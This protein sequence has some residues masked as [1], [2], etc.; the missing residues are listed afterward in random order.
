MKS[1]DDVRAKVVAAM[2]KD[3]EYTRLEIKVGRGGKTGVADL[4]YS[5]VTG[6][7]G[8][9][10]FKYIPELT[11]GDHVDIGLRRDQVDFLVNHGSYAGNASVIVGV[12]EGLHLYGFSWVHLQG[13]LG[14]VTHDRF[15]AKARWLV[16]E[17]RIHNFLTEADFQ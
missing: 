15:V 9:L 11:P 10:E 12:G 13:M 1:E 14:R 6:V 2:R 7:R 17:G 4:L 3:W 8:L 16:D 5:A